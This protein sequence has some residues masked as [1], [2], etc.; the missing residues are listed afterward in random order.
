MQRFLVRPA[1]FLVLAAAYLAYLEACDGRWWMAFLL[2]VAGQ[3]VG[4][5]IHE[6]GHALAALACGRQVYLFVVRPFGF[7]LLNRNLAIVPEGHNDGAGG[8]VFSAP[9]RPEADTNAA[10]GFVTA[11]GPAAS[12]LL[13]AWCFFAWPASGRTAIL[14]V[15]LAK[16]G[17]GLGIQALYGAIF[18]LLPMK[19]PG[20]SDGDQLRALARSGDPSPFQ[21]ALWL[22][23][24]LDQKVRLRD[25]P[26]W[27][28]AGTEA[29]APDH[30]GLQR[31]ID[32]VE[33]GRTLD[34][35][36]VDPARAR[37]LIERFRELY[38]TDGWL[39]ACDAWLAA[40]WEQDLDRARAAL[41]APHERPGVPELTMAAEA[42]IAARTGDNE[43]ARVLLREMMAIV[44]KQ[45]P[46][47]NQTYEDLRRQ[48]EA[49]LPA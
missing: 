26:D 11:A 15:T 33:V 45:S 1:A 17:I 19:V 46:F 21:P 31:W 40:V 49:L 5:F 25:L 44:R 47:R 10:W 43:R 6:L 29:V 22:K 8:W 32:G 42:A 30:E 34:A 9:R 41:D 39:A 36:N 12:L 7:H 48:V 20:Y 18:S 28:V 13:A 24:L 2:L 4:C 37:A 16:V 14:G 38:G 23:A 27:M 35:Q 3:F